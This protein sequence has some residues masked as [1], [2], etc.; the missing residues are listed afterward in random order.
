MRDPYSISSEPSGLN[1]ELGVAFP[2]RFVSGDE[3]YEFELVC[4]MDDASQNAFD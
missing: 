1:F 3:A 2:S 4:D